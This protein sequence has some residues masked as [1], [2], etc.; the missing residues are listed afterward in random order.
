MI[1]KNLYYYWKENLLYS[2]TFF[3]RYMS[4]KNWDTIIFNYIFGNLV[5]DSTHFFKTF[6]ASLNLDIYPEPSLTRSGLFFFFDYCKNIVSIS[7]TE[8]LKR[9]LNFFFTEELLTY[10]DLKLYY[11][12]HFLWNVNSLH[13]EVTGI[14]YMPVRDYLNYYPWER[15]ATSYKQQ[16]FENYVEKL[17]AKPIKT[18]NFSILFLS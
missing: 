5:N 10:E 14:Q 2:D 8:T 11:H 12:K 3:T 4:Y 1:R 6:Q 16:W 13:D 17:A 15:L 9:T 7:K 18:L